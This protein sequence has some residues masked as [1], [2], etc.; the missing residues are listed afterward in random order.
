LS[1]TVTGLDPKLIYI[2][3]AVL[4]V[5]GTSAISAPYI[6]SNDVDQS[7]PGEAQGENLNFRQ[8]DADDVLNVINNMQSGYI[9]AGEARGYIQDEKFYAKQYIDGNAVEA[10]VNVAYIAYLNAAIDVTNAYAN[11]GKDSR[12]FLEKMNIMEEKKNLI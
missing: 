10:E 7:L 12:E 2:V 8:A 9:T 11:Y 5:I 3:L 6:F 4:G 1:E